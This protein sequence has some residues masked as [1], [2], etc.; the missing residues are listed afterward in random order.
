MIRIAFTII[1][2]IVISDNVQG[3]IPLALS[4]PCDLIVSVPMDQHICDNNDF[5]FCGSILTTYPDLEV[6]WLLNGSSTNLDLCDQVDLSEPTTFTLMVTATNDLNLIVNGDFANGDDGSFTTDYFQG[7]GNCNHGAGFLGCEGAYNVLDDPSLGHNNFDDCNDF[8]GDGNMMV[9]NGAGN[10]QEIWCQEVCVDPDASYNFSAW[11][12]SVNP[13]SPA[14]LQFSIDGDLIGSIF[15]LTSATCSWQNF[16]SEWQSNGETSVRI[17]VTNQNTEDEGNDFA[18][19][20][21]E[22]IQFCHAEETFEVTISDVELDLDQSNDLTCE[23]T[24]TIIE[25]DISTPFNIDEISW[26]TEE[27]NIIDV[28]N[29]GEDVLVDAEGLYTVTVTDEFGCEFEDD[30]FIESEITEPD[31][32]IM[33]LDTLDCQTTSIDLLATSSIRDRDEEFEWSD[34]SGLFLGDEDQITVTSGGT[35][36]VTVTDD[37]SGCTNTAEIQISATFAPPSL[38]L[39]VSNNLDCN[40]NSALISTSNPFD[41]IA[42]TSL[43]TG[44]ITSSNDTLTVSAPGTYIAQLNQGACSSAD[45]LTITEIIPDFLYNIE[46]N[47]DLLTCT[48]TIAEVV[49][50]ID[51]N[52]FTVSWIGAASVFGNNTTVSITTPGT[53]QFNLLDSLGCITTDS[54]TIAEN[55]SAPL[56]NANATPIECSAPTSTINLNITNN[57][58]INEV[59][60][61]L[62][63]G[64]EIIDDNEIEVT[65]AGTV[66]Y[67]ATHSVTGC[68]ISSTIEVISTQEMPDL[69]LVSDT[70]S[71]NNPEAILSASSTH[72]IDSYTWT[73]PDGTQRTGASIMSNQ[74][75]T[76][77]VTVI[78]DMGC[79]VTD[80][81]DL[82]EN[83]DAPTLEQIDNITLTCMSLDT[84]IIVAVEQGV[85]LE[86]TT[87][88][89]TQ[90]DNEINISE[91]GNYL[92]EATN[93]TGC[94]STIG[95][96]V[97]EDM[98]PPEVEITTAPLDCENPSV[99]PEITEIS[100]PSISRILWTL[101]DGTTI[102]SNTF[103]VTVPGNYSASIT[104]D[105]GCQANVD[106]EVEEIEVNVDFDLMATPIDCNTTESTISL[107][108]NSTDINS[109][110][111]LVNNQPIGS[112]NE[113][114][115][116]GGQEVTALVTDRCGTQVSSSITPQVDT[117][118]VDLIVLADPLGCQVSGITLDINA[119]SNLQ[120]IQILD[121]NGDFIGDESALITDPG[122]YTVQAIGE[123]G[124]LTS[125]EVE[126]IEDNAV[127]DFTTNPITLDCNTPSASVDIITNVIYDS[128]TLLDS[129][130]DPLA[131]ANFGEELVVTE[132]GN[133]TLTILNINGC[134]SDQPLVVM[135]DD[136]E[137]DF[138]LNSTIINC[139]NTQS[140]VDILT[141]EIFAS[142]QVLNQE[143]N[144]IARTGLTSTITLDEP[145]DYTFIIENLNGCT[146]TETVLV[147]IDTSTI[148]FSLSGGLLTCNDRSVMIDITASQNFTS[149]SYTTPALERFPLNGDIAADQF[150]TYTI[151]LIAENGCSSLENIDILENEDIPEI[152]LFTAETLDCDG[153]GQINDFSI[154]GGIAPYEVR[155]DGQEIFESTTIPVNGIGIH[156]ISITDANG[157]QLDTS[158]VLEAVDEFNIVANPDLTIALGTEA[159][160]SVE[161]TFPLEDLTLNWSPATDLSCTDCPNP[162]FSGIESTTYRVTATNSFGCIAVAEVRI[163]IEQD[164]DVYIPNVIDI[165]GVSSENRFTIFTGED[166]IRQ[167]QNLSIFDRWG[168][169]VF[170]NENFQPN[171]LSQGWDGKINNQ[172]VDPGVFAYMT[173]IEYLDGTSEIF[174]G[175][176]TVIK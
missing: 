34:E 135:L 85:I 146:S 60:W 70:L 25:L 67:T 50:D 124:C 10:L 140:T 73:L 28:I 133:Y 129:N 172:E 48:D 114:T 86:W 43:E 165:S 164:I 150:G 91:A 121:I 79:E 101:P 71:C 126:V 13:G 149:G 46:N 145:G 3:H 98:T 167:V 57:V 93:T 9:V 100:G 138:D 166:D 161:S 132:A 111:F 62:P 127:V 36:T 162:V 11:A 88:S 157:C 49:V 151:E 22:F 15:D 170:I 159:Q 156:D 2:L 20:E 99:Q 23:E 41:S 120:G 171:D 35:Y 119:S 39:L 52:L 87:P 97:I 117:S 102:D 130:G 109:V 42:W 112:G 160:L 44:L 106:F 92:L 148:D 30:I 82:V 69:S 128:V 80:I 55:L 103:V 74:A 37:D 64:T 137:I 61:I 89:G 24:F 144:E 143:G 134:L 5:D 4:D 158:F 38:D 113:V 169:L 122:R 175:D 29:G 95:F 176:I 136:T 154:M 78:D 26:D 66:M 40:N 131:V 65:Q 123:N 118:K 84:T 125:E 141:N 168:N 77:T 27:G 1:L 147:D 105:N 16:E 56:T 76:Y 53:Y 94:Q 54:I 47:I 173:V 104:G 155:L 142:V 51:P 139:V 75:G 14:R 116:D 21:I 81:I 68:S 8:S 108:T 153:T 72:N 33:A 90:T 12:A 18:L 45:T 163:I 174:A 110:T 31:L 59:I 107:I 7:Q 83:A 115:I 58:V 32:D 63:D 96:E 6:E 19:D 152:I 17:C